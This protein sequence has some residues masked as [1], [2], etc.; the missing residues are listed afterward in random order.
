MAE[1]T[2]PQDRLPPGCELAASSFKNGGRGTGGF[3]PGLP[4]PTNPWTGTE[5]RMVATIRSQ[6]DGTPFSL[7]LADGVEEAYAAIYSQG[8]QESIVVY[9]LRFAGTAAGPAQPPGYESGPV[10]QRVPRIQVGPITVVLSGERA[11][12]SYAV[13]SYLRSLAR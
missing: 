12:C 10:V 9:A 3:W 5:R 4:I 1:L 8:D 7:P 13:E 6:M 2:V 11:E